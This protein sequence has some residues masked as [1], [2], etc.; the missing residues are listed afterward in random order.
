MQLENKENP[1]RWFVKK[2]VSHVDE[3]YMTRQVRFV[4]AKNRVG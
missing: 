2:Y 1:Q 3:V 4:A